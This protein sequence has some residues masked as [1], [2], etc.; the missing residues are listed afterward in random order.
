[1][2]ASPL[3]EPGAQLPRRA[4]TILVVDDE[5]GILEVLSLGLRSDDITVLTARDVAGGLR[6]VHS[7][8]PDLIVLDVGLPGGDGF[9][10]LRRIREV[11]DV[12]ILMLTARDD[13]EDRVRGLE[14]GADDYIAKPF[15]LEELMARVRA[16]LRRRAL[17]RDDRSP[18]PFLRSGDLTI[19]AAARRAS[20]GPRELELTSREFDL[21]ELLVRHR[22][23][24]LSKTR[25]LEA[26]WG[27][28]Y[29]PNLVE[30]YIGYLRRKLGE[31][32]LLETVRGSGYR[33]AAGD[34]GSERTASGPHPKGAA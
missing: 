33:L 20:R 26:L 32:P 18:A 22:G 13:V 15:H 6:A 21:F 27:Y 23:E 12:P 28:A 7:H 31:P 10:L 24:V 25:I 34:R 5:P 4:S 11:S 1:M 30:V 8:S 3:R 19:D 14:L 16:Q 29:D 9:S 17:D 2:S